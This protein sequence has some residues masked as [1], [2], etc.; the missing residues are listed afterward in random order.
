MDGMGDVRVAEAREFRAMHKLIIDA[1]EAAYAIDS[2]KA[3]CN[4][5]VQDVAKRL[6]ITSGVEGQANNIYD[7]IDHGSPW[8]NCGTGLAG[9]VKAAHYAQDGFFVVAAWKN[10]TGDSGHVAAVVGLDI[11]KGAKSATSFHVVASW[12]VKD[13]PDEA[14]HLGGIRNTFAPS[15]KLPNVIF[16]AQCIQKW[17]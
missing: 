2:N 13:C 3:A 5:F 12:G 10:P 8:I 17:S 4:F 1:C 7:S 9:S 6:G 15:S 11:P 16:G 14:V